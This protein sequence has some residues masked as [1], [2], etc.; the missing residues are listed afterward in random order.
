MTPSVEEA[1]ALGMVS[2]IFPADELADKTLEFARRIAKVP[3]M[4]ALLVK[5][6]VNQTQ[7]NQGFYN[8]LNA[9]F[10][11]HELNHSHWA[12]VHE[13]KFPVGLAEDGLEDWRP[14]PARRPR[15][16]TSPAPDFGVIGCARRNQSRRNHGGG[17]GLAGRARHIRCG[18]RTPLPGR[19]FRPRRRRPCRSR[20]AIALPAAN[21]PGIAFAADVQHAAVP[22]VRG[23]PLVPIAPTATGTA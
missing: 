1:H 7:D 3:T 12:Q 9:C 10:T 23:P 20:P 5:E 13:H 4:A 21:S 2:K 6:S 16:K 14:R 18:S 11:L 22:S 17:G 15:S 19:G 8:S